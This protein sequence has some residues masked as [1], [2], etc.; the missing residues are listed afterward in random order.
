M[1]RGKAVPADDRSAGLRMEA[2]PPA[3]APADPAAVVA[4]TRQKPRLWTAAGPARGAPGRVPRP[5][6]SR[7]RRDGPV[8]AQRAWAGHHGVGLRVAVT[9]GRPGGGAVGG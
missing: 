8:A 7:S 1:R 3:T 9:P 5:T 4:H 6:G 2:P